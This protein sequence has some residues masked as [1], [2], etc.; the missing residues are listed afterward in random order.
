M[1]IQSVQKLDEGQMTTLGSRVKMRRGELKISR[2]AL[3]RKV[4]VS[5]A[6]IQK[7]EENSTKHP[8]YLNRIAETL[9]VEAPWLLFGVDIAR[10]GSLKISK[11]ELDLISFYRELNAEEKQFICKCIA[12]LVEDSG[13]Q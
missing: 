12:G 6:A 5:V 10:S 8:K 1:Y 2:A 7:I 4:G 9:G 3:A 13:R 11:E